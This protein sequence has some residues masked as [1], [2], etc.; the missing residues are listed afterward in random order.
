MNDRFLDAYSRLTSFPKV[1]TLG[2]HS[3]SDAR[4]L[5]YWII[6]RVPD[7]CPDKRYL[8]EKYKYTRH[9]ERER[10][11]VW[12][13]PQGTIRDLANRLGITFLYPD[14][15]PLI[16]YPILDQPL[17]EIKLSQAS[18]SFVKWLSSNYKNPFTVSDALNAYLDEWSLRVETP[19]ELIEKLEDLLIRIKDREEEKSDGSAADKI[20]NLEEIYQEVIRSVDDSIEWEALCKL[21]S[22]KTGVKLSLIQETMAWRRTTV[23]KNEL[24]MFPFFRKFIEEVMTEITDYQD[25][26]LSE[27]WERYLEPYRQRSKNIQ[28]MND[29]ARQ[30]NQKNREKVEAKK[31][32]NEEDFL[33]DVQQ[34]RDM[35]ERPVN[36]RLE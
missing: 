11:R 29:F 35:Y 25:S 24:L 7:L 18:S 36:R 19:E 5:K 28:E 27:W 16:Q 4:E 20:R 31:R 3:F 26:I 10:I 14:P 8:L 2:P 12:A 1:F 6:A 30:K 17:V 22:Q 15:G 33:H 34:V 13:E 23:T 32:K 9:F 21:L